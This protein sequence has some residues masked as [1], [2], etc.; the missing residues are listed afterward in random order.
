M[1]GA[2]RCEVCEKLGKFGSVTLSDG[3]E[4][5][6]MPMP[7]DIPDGV[8]SY[9]ELSGPYASEPAWRIV[10]GLIGSDDIWND[11]QGHFPWLEMKY[12]IGYC[13]VCGQSFDGLWEQFNERS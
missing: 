12:G 10:A 4:V 3:F 7:F 6:G 11:G 2:K 1:S 5:E 9:L 8:S 13:P